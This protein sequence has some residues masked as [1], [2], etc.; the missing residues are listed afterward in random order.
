MI[1]SKRESGPAVGK[2]SKVPHHTHRGAELVFARIRQVL[3]EL[4]CLLG[5][6][7]FVVCQWGVLITEKVFSCWTAGDHREPCGKRHSTALS[8]GAKHTRVVIAG[9]LSECA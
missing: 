7:L 3:G 4:S 2:S 6:P 1:K 5:M 9:D 8:T